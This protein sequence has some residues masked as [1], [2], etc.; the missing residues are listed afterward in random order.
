MS[1]S[2]TTNGVQTNSEVYLQLDVVNSEVIDKIDHN[3]RILT[4]KCGEIRDKILVLVNNSENL[5]F[6][7]LKI[8]LIEKSGALTF[9][10]EK[11]KTVTFRIH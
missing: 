11:T 1:T 5:A 8:N 4:Q 7:E 6:N 2:T 10:T 9:K 3:E